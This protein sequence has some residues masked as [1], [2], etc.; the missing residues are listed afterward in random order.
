M[1]HGIAGCDRQSVRCGEML[2]YKER[3]MAKEIE[4]KFLVVGDVWR[5]LA[6]GVRY[7]QGYLSSAKER[8]VRIRT[9][10]DRAFLTVKGPTV[11]VTRLEFEYPVPY[12]DGV[13]MLENLAEQPVIEK[14]RYKIPADGFVWEIDEFLGANKG[15][16]TAEIELR[17]EDQPFPKPEWIGEEV[18]GDPRYYNAMLVAHPYTTWSRK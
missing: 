18:S 11:G 3:L 2:F 6:Q 9:V 8:T 5:R 10:G 16:I 12:E 1:D 15:L 7:R 17:S 14:L 4:R 13:A